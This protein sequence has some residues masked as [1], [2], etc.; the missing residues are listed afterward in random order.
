[1]TN[2]ATT[3]GL[4]LGTTNQASTGLT[5]GGTSQP[6]TTGFGLGGTSQPSST[7]FGLGGTSQTTSTGFGLGAKPPLQSGLT[8]GAAGLNLGQTST[9]D[10]I[11][12]YCQSLLELLSD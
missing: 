12:N 9:G 11:Y 4:T 6:S 5:L 2:P 1:M 7:G 8:V 3:T 10:L